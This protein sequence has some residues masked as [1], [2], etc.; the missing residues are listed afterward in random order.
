MASFASTA[1]NINSLPNISRNSYILLANNLC[2]II[3]VVLAIITYDNNLNIL[4]KIVLTLKETDIFYKLLKFKYIFV[5]PYFC[6]ILFYF[7]EMATSNITGWMAKLAIRKKSN[8]N[9]I[10]F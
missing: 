6:S 7:L 5:N 10:L 1:L 3:C 2:Y 9:F 4:I 8:K